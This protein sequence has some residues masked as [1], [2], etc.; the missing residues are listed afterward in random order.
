[1]RSR[2]SAC[3][4]QD[5]EREGERRMSQNHAIFESALRPKMS[6][7]L[8]HS[9]FSLSV[10][11]VGFSKDNVKVPHFC[12]EQSGKKGNAHSVSH[13]YQGPGA[14]SRTVTPLPTPT[15]PTPRTPTHNPWN[16]SS[17]RRLNPPT[18]CH[19]PGCEVAINRRVVALPLPPLAPLPRQWRAGEE[20]PCPREPWPPSLIKLSMTYAAAYRPDG[21]GRGRVHG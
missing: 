20:P 13:T 15:P 12:K 5:A 1:M 9:L 6:G 21:S 17:Q 7:S 2:E 10:V 11:C 4:A 19:R 18:V 16:W 3:E 8:S 14:H